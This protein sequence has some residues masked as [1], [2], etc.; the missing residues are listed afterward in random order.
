MAGE[1]DPCTVQQGAAGVLAVLTRYF[2]LT[3]DPRLPERISTAGHWIAARTDTRSTRPGLHFGGRGTAWAL[4]DAGRAVDD[5]ALMD[6]ALALA[7]APQEPTPSHDITHGSAGSGLAAAHLWHR[8][9]DPRLAELV[10]DAAD[11]LAAAARPEPSGVSWPVPAE[12]VS[13]EAGKRYLGFAHGTSGIGCFLLA[14]AAVTNRREHLDLALAAGEE[15][16]ATALTVGETAQ[17]PAQAGDV[18]T[19]PYWCHGSAGIGSF[20]VRLWQTTGDDRFG[21]LARGAVRAVVDRASR[22]PSPNATDWRATATSSSTW[23]RPR[24]TPP[25]ARR[26]RTWPA[27]S[28]PNGPTAT[29]T[30]SSPTST[31]TS[32]RAGATGPQESWRSSCGPATRTPGSG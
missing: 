30:S 1:T 29:A 23:P 27:S 32:R 10:A 16:V 9:G 12:A 31:G 7:L 19:A 2:E 20:L 6:H 17:W 4:Y 5:R 8:T 15:L 13:K 24:G 21:D 18:P 28:S 3:G 11:R 14:A 26:P 25:T 22:A